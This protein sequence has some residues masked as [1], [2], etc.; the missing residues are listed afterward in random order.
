MIIKSGGAMGDRGVFGIN[1]RTSGSSN[2]EAVQ[3][4]F[5]A[6]DKSVDLVQMPSRVAG[7]PATKIMGSGKGDANNHLVEYYISHPSGREYYIMLLAPQAQ[8][9]RFS[10]RFTQ[11]LQSLSFE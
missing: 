3:K 6:S 9:P 11:I 7:L 4:E 8:W 5:E 10:S 1:L 2:H